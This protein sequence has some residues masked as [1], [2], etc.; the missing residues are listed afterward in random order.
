MRRYK[1]THILLV[2]LITL[3]TYPCIELIFPLN[4]AGSLNRSSESATIETFSIKKWLDG[5][6]QESVQN[7]VNDNIGL[8]PFF[9]KLHN[10]IEYSL[11]ENIYTGNVVKGKD[12]YLF[13]SGYI[14]AYLGED[15]NGLEKIQR[16]TKALKVL[17]D[18][19]LAMNKSFVFVMAS[20]KASYFPEYLP[21][22]KEPD[23]TNFEFYLKEFKK[24]GINHINCVNWFNQ[25]KDSLGHLLFPKY[26]IHW[27]NYG[28]MLVTDSLVKYHEKEFNWDLPNMTIEALEISK[29]TKFFDNDIAHSMNLFHTVE[30]FPYMMYP[31]VKWENKKSSHSK[32]K[33]LIIG[34]SFTWDIYVNS[35]ISNQSFENVD[36][37]YYN[38]MVNAEIADDGKILGGLPVLTRHLNINSVL[39]KYDGFIVI[40]NEPNLADLGWNIAQDFIGTILDSNFIPKE[41]NNAYL[42]DQCK[43]KKEWRNSLQQ[44]ANKNQISLDS[45]IS[46]YLHNKNFNQFK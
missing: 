11:F 24:E 15:F 42:I 5:T 8:F 16:K 46:V 34:D 33:M 2:V 23:S 12:N 7:Y 25:L 10:Q 43:S 40:S 39:K 19:L 29:K 27:S 31:T 30:P 1:T 28:A 32:K 14:K 18:S 4:L 6:F 22:L 36:F 37:W 3:L 13:E 20:G 21:D 44:L 38:Q 41:R 35:G 17:Q 45:M 26:G 9:I